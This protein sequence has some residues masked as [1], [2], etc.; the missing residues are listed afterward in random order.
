MQPPFSPFGMLIAIGKIIKRLARILRRTCQSTPSLKRRNSMHANQL[1]DLAAWVAIHSS[2][3]VYGEG[4]NT[5]LNVQ[6]YWAQSKCRIARW[7]SAVK[8]FSHDLNDPECSHN[9]WPAIEIVV[10]EIVVSELLTRVM[11]AALVVYDKYSNRDELKGIAHSVLISHMET[12][13]RAMRLL[14]HGRALNEQVFDR[15]NQLRRQVERWTDLFLSRFDNSNAASEFG[16]NPQR[17]K[18][19]AGERV[20]YSDEEFRRGQQVF[21]QSMAR[22]L[23]ACTQKFAA[24]PDLNRSIATSVLGCFI[25][26]RFDSFG[27]PKSSQL[28]WIEKSHNDTQMLVQELNDFESAAEQQK[29]NLQRSRRTSA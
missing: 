25:K 10:E 8:M 18:D 26:D 15:I 20:V 16:F 22:N 17:V 1:A 5:T 13:N 9:P 2:T 21:I 3:F 24:N 11:S 12:R 7:N 14:L 23:N 6:D 27:L 29:E 28:L 4:E 19:F